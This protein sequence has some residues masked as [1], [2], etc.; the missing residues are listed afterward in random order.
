MKRGILIVAVI[1]LFMVLSYSRSEAQAFI[2][3]SPF[4]SS[5]LAVYPD[6]NAFGDHA[7]ITYESTDANGSYFA[8]VLDANGVPRP[9]ETYGWNYLFADVRSDGYLDVYGSNTGYS[10]DWHYIAT[11]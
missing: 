2:A 7:M 9:S 5:Y 1:G 6:F 3:D 10:D 11:F 4:T 8:V